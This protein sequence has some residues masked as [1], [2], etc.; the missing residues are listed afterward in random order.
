M[1]GKKKNQRKLINMTQKINKMSKPLLDSQIVEK[2]KKK[3]NL[4]INFFIYF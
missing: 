1:I 4:I 2:K 3:K